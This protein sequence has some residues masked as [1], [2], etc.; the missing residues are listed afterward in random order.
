MKLDIL[1][2][3]VQGSC[4]WS[5]PA[6]RLPLSYDF[7]LQPR[8]DKLRVCPTVSH[9]YGFGL[10]DAEAMVKEAERW[11]QVPT[12]HVCVE[13]A[14]R[15]IRWNTNWKCTFFFSTC[16][17][18][19]HRIWMTYS[20]TD[21]QTDTHWWKHN[22]LGGGNANLKITS[23]SQLPFYVTGPL[24]ES[25]NDQKIYHIWMEVSGHWHLT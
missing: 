7:W 11:K 17:M 6:T 14:D 1:N 8:F 24:V 20:L 16:S 23:A 13:S 3:T 5:H 15:Q 12:Q 9:L 22:L 18:F 21:T 2:V 19:K 4:C 25:F 10:M